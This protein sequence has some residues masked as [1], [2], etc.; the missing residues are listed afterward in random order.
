[1]VSGTELAKKSGEQMKAAQQSTDDLAS[2]VSQIAKE[3]R[4]QAELTENTKEKALRIVDS[5]LKSA[6]ELNNQTKETAALVTYAKRMMESVQVFRL[7]QS[8]DS[9]D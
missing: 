3:S 8:K 1:M 2:A 6:T 9:E 5:T 7:P 4:Q